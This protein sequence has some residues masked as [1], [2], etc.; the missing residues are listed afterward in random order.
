MDTIRVISADGAELVSRSR[1]GGKRSK[2]RLEPLIFGHARGSNEGIQRGGRPN[3]NAQDELVMFLAIDWSIATGTKPSPGRS[4]RNGFGD[5]VHSVF[6]WIDEPS[7]HQ[8]LRRYWE[9][10]K[11]GQSPPVSKG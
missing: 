5:L 3:H 8:A 1:G 2:G 9:A 7:P 6:Q 11:S 10:V 4:D